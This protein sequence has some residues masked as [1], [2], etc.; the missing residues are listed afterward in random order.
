MKK[1][2]VLVLLSL[3][4]IPASAKPRH[5]HPKRIPDVHQNVLTAHASLGAIEEFAGTFGIE[6]ECFFTRDRRF[7]IN[8]PVSVYQAGTIGGKNRADAG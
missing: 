7:S 5:Q 4:S 6:Y 1:A 8:V 3:L 2:Y